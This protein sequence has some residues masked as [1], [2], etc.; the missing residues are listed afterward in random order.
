[1]KASRRVESGS[2]KTPLARLFQTE[3]F[4]NVIEPPKGSVAVPALFTVLPSSREKKP[5]VM[6]E[7]P[8]R[9]SAPVPPMT[10]LVQLKLSLT[11]IAPVPLTVP[12]TVRLAALSG[13]FAV[14]VPPL[15]TRLFTDELPATVSVLKLGS[16]AI[17]APVTAAPA[18]KV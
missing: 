3:P 2:R 16:C 1:K 4:A 11:L 6:V 10:P 14:N 12:L 5:P 15:R 17:P 13:A 18:W 7:A 9:F 8:L